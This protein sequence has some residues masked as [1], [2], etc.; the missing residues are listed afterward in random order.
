MWIC[1]LFFCT[2]SVLSAQTNSTDTTRTDTTNQDPS[3]VRMIQY[4]GVVSS[5]SANQRSIG[6][7]AEYA[8]QYGNAP[9]VGFGLN[10]LW[11]GDLLFKTNQLR[12]SFTL[13]KL[14]N[15][16]P[17]SRILENV[18]GSFQIG[19]Y[20]F[21]QP[22]F[23]AYPFLG[24]GSSIFYVENGVR[25]SVTSVE[26]GAGA[27]YYIPKTPLMIGLQA[28]YSHGFN[29]RA[30]QDIANNQSGFTA[31]AHVSLYIREKFNYW[32]WD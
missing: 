11:I 1:I 28:A 18:R 10:I 5:M 6:I 23:K 30:P 19:Y 26:G 2:A 24:F 21:E 17:S 9:L 4:L 29:I 8:R 14:L 15:V 7:P 22:N 3:R 16:Y 13:E 27:D 20:V 31:R 32:G 12:S 25:L